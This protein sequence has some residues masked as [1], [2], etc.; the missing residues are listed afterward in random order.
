MS[1]AAPPGRRRWPRWWPLVAPRRR[2]LR[3]GD[4]WA[5]RSRA[6]MKTS[7][8]SS[9]AVVRR[10]R[11]AVT[12]RARRASGSGPRTCATR[13]HDRTGTG[14]RV[15][16]RK[17]VRGIPMA[18]LRSSPRHPKITKPGVRRFSIPR[19]P[20]VRSPAGVR[21]SP[22]SGFSELP[23]P[24]S[25]ASRAPASAGGPEPPSRNRGCPESHGTPTRSGRR[26]RGPPASAPPSGLRRFRRR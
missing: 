24:F 12:R 22:D 15:G 18:A 19:N 9:S 25:A 23:E 2:A 5:T 6:R 4:S 16:H 14:E 3:S 11:E 7:W 21:N 26:P 13:P 17:S 20:G 1:A 10:C 8:V